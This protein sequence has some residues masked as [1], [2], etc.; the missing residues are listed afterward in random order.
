METEKIDVYSMGNVFY[1]LLTETWP[2]NDENS[3]DAQNS[4][5]A[6]KRPHVPSRLRESKDP[7][8]VAIRKAMTMSWRQDPTERASAKEVSNF[9]QQELKALGVKSEDQ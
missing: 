9:L 1:T 6:G 3:E 4:V 8:I 5:K 2:F 7:A